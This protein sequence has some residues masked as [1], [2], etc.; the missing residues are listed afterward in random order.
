M[1]QYPNITG[2]TTSKPN[3]VCMFYQLSIT[4]KRVVKN[5]Q[6][7]RL[8]SITSQKSSFFFSV[9]PPAMGIYPLNG[10]DR[11]KDIG[12][13]KNPSAKLVNVVSKNG[14]DGLPAASYQLQGF[15]NSYIYF[16]NTG[17]LDTQ[18]SITILLWLMPE[19]AGPIFHYMPRGIGVNLRMIGRKVIRAEFVSR[20][21]KITRRISRRIRSR[22][23]NYIAATY[24]YNTGLA[25]LWL[26]AI[27]ITQENIGRFR[28]ATN[29]PAVSGR[30][31]GDPRHFRGRIA[32]LQIY[33]L[34]LNSYQIRKLK[35][36]CFR[37]SKYLIL[38]LL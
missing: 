22:V 32:C 3:R 26:D 16:P 17:R 5:Q 29:Y 34:A 10:I 31:P 20:N 18:N 6:Q 14:P 24:D 23:W 4:V 12:P 2:F 35:R 19:S 13:F 8:S 25:T 38:D 11:G 15:A 37:A 36:F 30:R 1:S 21:R 33:S 9:P 27:P 28:L 7:N